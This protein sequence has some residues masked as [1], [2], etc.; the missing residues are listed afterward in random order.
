MCRIE[1]EIDPINISTTYVKDCSDP[2][3]FQFFGQG[4]E[5]KLLGLFPTDRHLFTVSEGKLLLFGADVN[6]RDIYSRTIYGARVSLTIGLLGV[7]IA[8]VLGSVIG[9]ISG[10]AGGP[11]DT[12]IQRITE[13]II[14]IPTLP[15][16]ATMAAVLPRTCRWCSATS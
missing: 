4:F 12:I 5:Y 16:W 8:T 13:V 2:I 7:L 1:Q 9:T 6:G 15:L 14:S 11:V 10:Y 3:P